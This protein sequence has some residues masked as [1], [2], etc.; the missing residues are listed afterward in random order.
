MFVFQFFVN[1][2][3]IESLFVYPKFSFPK[4]K[5][6]LFNNHK[7]IITSIRYNFIQTCFFSGNM[8]EESHICDAIPTQLYVT[9]FVPSSCQTAKS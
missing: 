8:K 2:L 7:V 9:D 1:H 5:N 6:I 4:N 3:K